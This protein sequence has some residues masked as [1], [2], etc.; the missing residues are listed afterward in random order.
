[1]T[2][3][4]VIFKTDYGEQMGKSDFFWNHIAPN[5]DVT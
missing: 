4:L 2:G 5:V 3:V 1:M